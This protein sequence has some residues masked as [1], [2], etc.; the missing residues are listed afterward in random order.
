MVLEKL[1]ALY[2]KL[3]EKG[4]TLERLWDCYAIQKSEKV[5]QTSTVRQLAD[6]VSLVRF[7]MGEADSLQP[8]A[9]KVNYNFQQWTF[10]RNAGAVHFTPEQ[11]EW[12]QLV[13]DHIATSLSIQPED[14][15]LSP[16][17]RRG[18]LGRFYE[19]FGDKYEE[20]LREMNRE[21]VA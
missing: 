17:D 16:F 21:L 3:R 6:L 10:R 12:L 14:L 5:K 8:F 13:K 9:D 18:G 1:K 15:D 19:V 7:E 2:E 11:M 20:I 4:V